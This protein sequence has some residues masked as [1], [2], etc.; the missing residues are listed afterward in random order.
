MNV[1]SDLTLM[2]ARLFRDE[3]MGLKL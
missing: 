1:S 2:D 3:L